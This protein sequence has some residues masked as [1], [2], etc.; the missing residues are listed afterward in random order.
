METMFFD[1]YTDSRLNNLELQLKVDIEQLQRTRSTY[2]VP[3]VYCEKLSDLITRYINSC[4]NEIKTDIFNKVKSAKIIP[5]PNYEEIKN[6]IDKRINSI[7]TRQLL[8]LESEVS[9]IFRG[10]QTQIKAVLEHISAQEKCLNNLKIM[11]NEFEPEFN[12][13]IFKQKNEEFYLSQAQEANKIAQEAN[14]IAKEAN[15]IS[16]SN[17]WIAWSAFAISIIGLSFTGLTYFSGR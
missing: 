17:K 16:K 1:G 6:F 7:L 8:L 10:N 9:I 14:K 13:Y 11:H 12:E 4:I 15:Q 5:I 2:A 3:L